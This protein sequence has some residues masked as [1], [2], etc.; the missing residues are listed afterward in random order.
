MFHRLHKTVVIQRY[1]HSGYAPAYG[2][3]VS[4]LIHYAKACIKYQ[5]LIEQGKLL[6][7]RLL[8]QGNQRTKLGSTL[9]KFYGRYRHLVDPFNVAVSRIVSDVFF[10][11]CFFLPQTRHRQT[12]PGHSFLPTFQYYQDK[13]TSLG[14]LLT[15][16]LFGSMNVRP[17]IILMYHLS[18]DS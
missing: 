9:K 18:I 1:S 5:D 6:I 10:F 2:V 15:P 3:N 16:F 4:P 11:V 17:N 13:F 14:R 7:T 12:H 8:S